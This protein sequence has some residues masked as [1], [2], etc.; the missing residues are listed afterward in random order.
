MTTQLQLIIIIII[1][2][3][4]SVGTYRHICRAE[5]RVKRDTVRKGGLRMA[6]SLVFK[7]EKRTGVRR[8]A[9]FTVNKF[10]V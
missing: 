2:I 5:G 4:L 8:K 3:I 1:I 6:D 9:V 7:I 10:C